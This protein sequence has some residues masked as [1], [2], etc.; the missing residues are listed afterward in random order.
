[1]SGQMLVT[2]RKDKPQ[3]AGIMAQASWELEFIRQD[4]H[5][6]V[7]RGSNAN[8]N[9]FKEHNEWIASITPIED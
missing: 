9:L 7:L 4:Q 2:L 1:M 6:I 3:G 5:G 8:L